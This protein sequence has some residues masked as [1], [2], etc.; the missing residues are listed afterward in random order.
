MKV[1]P[2]ELVSKTTTA[3]GAADD[4]YGLRNR[5]T[6]SVELR[7]GEEHVTLTQHLTNRGTQPMQSKM[8]SVV[9]SP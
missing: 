7:L 5:E 9:P 4:L 3:A 6:R 8:A 2:F 1:L